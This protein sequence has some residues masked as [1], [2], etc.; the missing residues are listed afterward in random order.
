MVFGV[1]D[2][3]GGPIELEQKGYPS[4]SNDDRGSGVAQMNYKDL[5]GMSMASQYLLF[6]ARFAYTSSGNNK[7][8]GGDVTLLG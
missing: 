7:S 6:Q 3:I 2:I 8:F 5:F 4:C 1:K